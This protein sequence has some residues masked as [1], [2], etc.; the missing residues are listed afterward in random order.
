M[1]N[2]YDNM[3]AGYRGRAS[4]PGCNDTCGE[5]ARLF[6]CYW[7]VQE[8]VNSE[9]ITISL[10]AKDCSQDL[11]ALYAIPYRDPPSHM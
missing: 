4:T 5:V 6:C 11:T 7:L 3:Q 1:H 9:N 8:N 2:R 10:P